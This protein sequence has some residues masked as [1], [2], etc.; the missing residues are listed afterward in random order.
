[1]PQRASS[2][3]T[4]HKNYTVLHQVLAQAVTDGRL[5]VNT[6]AE[7]ELPTIEETEKRYLTA[8]QIRGLADAAGEH[9]AL[10]LLLGF[11]GLR[12]GEAAALTVADIDLLHG[13][14]RVH[15]S[16]TAV[17]GKMVYSAPKSHQARTVP[18]PQFLIDA[19][20][21][22]LADSD[23]AAL[24]FP[25]SRGGPMRLSNVRRRWWGRAVA[26]SGAPAGL[27]PHELRHSAAS[28]AISAG[29]SIKVVQKMLGHKSATL[30]LDRYGHLYQDDL[31]NV[32]DRLDSMHAAAKC[33]QNVP[34]PL[35]VVR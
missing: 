17:D 31:Q 12:F 33:A 20:R 35:R 2:A 5:T 18:L 4:V 1:M 34:T 15:R 32:A 26:D 13:R 27:C 9:G 8:G 6:A 14:V 10:V 11:T 7:L 21:E 3:A 19:L 16:V 24:A 28:M 25:D 22:H 29:A 23:P 30:T